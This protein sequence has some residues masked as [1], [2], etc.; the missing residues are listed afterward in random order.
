VLTIAAWELYLIFVDEQEKATADLM[1]L[2]TGPG[3]GTPP[4]PVDQQAILGHVFDDRH[5]QA[6]GGLHTV[7]QFFL[8]TSVWNFDVTHACVFMWCKDTR[9]SEST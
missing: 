3:C 2:D 6:C 8:S 9:S 7:H 1:T 4:H 5:R